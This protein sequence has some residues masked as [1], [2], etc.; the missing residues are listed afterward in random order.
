ME[1]TERQKFPIPE[2]FLP[3]QAPSGSLH[4][5]IVADH[6]DRRGVNWGPKPSDRSR[7]STFTT[8]RD[9]LITLLGKLA[10]TLARTRVRLRWIITQRDTW[11]GKCR[12]EKSTIVARNNENATSNNIN[13]SSGCEKKERLGLFLI[14]KEGKKER[15]G[16]NRSKSESGK[17]EE[18]EQG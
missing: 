6:I 17:M 3:P 10:A 16:E 7:S 18:G 5:R 13:S 4:G 2:N 9:S 11:G 8:L 15:K 14:T 12:G 1:C